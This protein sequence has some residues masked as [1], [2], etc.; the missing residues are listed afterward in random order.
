MF[1]SILEGIVLTRP[2]SSMTTPSITV[3]GTFRRVHHS[4]PFAATVTV[5][6]E[7]DMPQTEVHVD[8][9]GKGWGGS[10][11]E[12]DDVSAQGYD[13]WKA[14]AVHG[15]RYALEVAQAPATRVTIT[16]IAGRDGTDTNPTIVGA[17]AADAVWKA[18]AYQPSDETRHHIESIVFTS[19][20]RPEALPNFGLD[21]DSTEQAHL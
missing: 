6:V 10:Q 8:C 11:G 18:I 21:H 14:A 20:Q 17:A 5:K 13:D 19:W 4:L 7:F 2:S 3:D 15:V 9:H 1:S 16:R 12:L